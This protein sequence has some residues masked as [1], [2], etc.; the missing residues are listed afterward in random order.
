MIIV[1][2]NNFIK[3]NE[4]Y[5]NDKFKKDIIEAIESLEEEILEYKG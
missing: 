2:K 3:Y 4:V 5:M 1:M